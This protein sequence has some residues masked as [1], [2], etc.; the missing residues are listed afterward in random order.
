MLPFSMLDVQVGAVGD[1]YASSS[2]V[3]SSPSTS[4]R[5]PFLGQLM[6]ARRLRVSP[7]A[8]KRPMSRYAYKS[9]RVDRRTYKA[10][11]SIDILSTNRC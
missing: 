7:R 4:I 2:R 10:S 11:I 8:V 3:R 9:L 1:E 5:A 6:P